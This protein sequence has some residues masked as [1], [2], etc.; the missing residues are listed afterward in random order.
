MVPWFTSGGVSYRVFHVSNV[1]DQGGQIL[2]ITGD[3][4]GDPVVFNFSQNA[5]LQ[6]DVSLI[7]LTGDQVLWNFAGGSNGTGG[8]AMSLNNNASSFPNLAWQGVLLDPNGM[9]SVTN[10]KLV[11][12]VFGGDDH[13]TQIVSGA[14]ITTAVPEPSTLLLLGVSFGLLAITL[15]RKPLTAAG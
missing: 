1:Q 8:P 4:S 9:I 7:G 3:G 11:G 2:T 14:T 13:D 10:A 5:N 12:S 6:G 15:R